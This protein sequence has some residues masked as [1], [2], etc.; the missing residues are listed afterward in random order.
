[1]KKENGQT[2][3]HRG[4]NFDLKMRGINLRIWANKAFL[5]LSHIRRIILHIHFSNI[6]LYIWIEMC[7][8]KPRKINNGGIKFKIFF[9]VGGIS[10]TL[11]EL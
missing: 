10:E 2:I 9:P 8:H 6:Y 3:Y 7:T 4:K 11:I 5:F 1:M